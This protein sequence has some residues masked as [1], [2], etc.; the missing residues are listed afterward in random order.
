MKKHFLLFG[1]AFALLA[2]SCSKNNNNDEP[3]IVTPPNGST[4]EVSGDIKINTTWTADKIYQLKGY[5]YVTD[6]A[7]LTIEPGTI[8]KGDKASKATLVITR[9]AKINA[10]GTVDKPIVFTSGAASGARR[11]GDWVD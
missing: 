4:M 6:G 3:E 11:E 8:I 2:T 9:G 7:T 1:L 10:V 5:V